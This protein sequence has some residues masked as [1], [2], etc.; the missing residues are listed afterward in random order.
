M[1]TLKPTGKFKSKKTIR[2]MTPMARKL[3]HHTRAAQSVVNRLKYLTDE[4]QRLEM[5]AIATDKALNARIVECEYMRAHWTPPKDL[6][7][8]SQLWPELPNGE[9]TFEGLG[10]PLTESEILQGRESPPGCDPKG[11][12][13]LHPSDGTLAGYHSGSDADPRD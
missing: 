13:G 8:M 12:E 6:T 4:L 2:R 5:V 10:L 3:A 11:G 1:K 9:G 7:P